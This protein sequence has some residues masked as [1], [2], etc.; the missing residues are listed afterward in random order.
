MIQL[1]RARRT[2]V[3][4][5][6]IVIE[7]TGSIR[8]YG[9][10]VSRNYLQEECDKLIKMIAIIKHLERAAFDKKLVQAGG[11]ES[12]AL[13]QQVFLRQNVYG[14]ECVCPIEAKLWIPN[15]YSHF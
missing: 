15:C 5:Y 4:L 8:F 12:T 6:S 2:E 7:P 1:L 3:A 11:F 10:G 9:Q 14:P 13:I